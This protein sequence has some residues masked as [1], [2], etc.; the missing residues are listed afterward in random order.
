L[1]VAT[2]IFFSNRN[3][4]ICPAW[5]PLHVLL[6]EDQL[7]PVVRIA[8]PLLALGLPGGSEAIVDGTPGEGRQNPDLRRWPAAPRWS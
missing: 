1:A 5:A 8:Q 4:F 7:P 2:A 6:D 3:C